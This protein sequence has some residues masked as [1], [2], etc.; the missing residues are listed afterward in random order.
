MSFGWGL[1]LLLTFAWQHENSAQ[2][3]LI[4]TVIQEEAFHALFNFLVRNPFH[5]LSP[6][7]LAERF[8]L[9]PNMLEIGFRQHFALPI[10][11]FT[12]MVKMMTIFDSI[13]NE[14]LPL[15]KI[16]RQYGFRN[17][18]HLDEVFKEHYDCSVYALLVDHP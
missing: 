18:T 15:H 11:T 2:P 9:S 1:D 6:P 10:E 17:T 16:A 4:Y 12:F 13:V 14:K 7:A 5:Q 3:K 8:G